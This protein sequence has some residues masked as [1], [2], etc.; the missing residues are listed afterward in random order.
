MNKINRRQFL[1]AGTAGLAG[2]SVAGKGMAGNIYSLANDVVVDKVKLGNTG[3][4][5][6][7][8]AMGT[9][10]RGYNRSSNQTRA[11]MDHFKRML[12]HAY[13]RGIRFYDMADF[14]GSMPFVGESMKGLPREN[15][16]L[17]SKMLT[18][19]DGSTMNE[20]VSQLLDRFRKEANT[21]YFDVIL[22]HCMMQGNWSNTRKHYIDG[23]AKAKQDGI[24]KAVGISSHHID[25]LKEA[26]ESPWVDV[27]LAR[28]NPFGK[29]MDGDP[30]VVT[31]IL[32]KAIQNGKGVIGMKIFAEGECVSDQEREE[33]IRF[34]VTKK[35][36]HCMTMGLETE[37]Q[38][39]DAIERVMRHANNN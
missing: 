33:S 38:M 3:L 32:L 16:T 7:R 20:P 8:M 25:A 13:E 28:I 15:I 26:A 12:N 21:D 27:I 17:L 18:Y 24:V 34:S 14:Y 36:V 37:D 11:G 23:L 9:G 30:D 4:T 22:M 39:D 2:L 29:N 31:P 10:T 6:S 35:H 5:V 1:L 19:E